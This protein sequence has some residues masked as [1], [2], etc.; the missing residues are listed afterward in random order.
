MLLPLE[1]NIRI[2]KDQ[3]NF[4]NLT[5]DEVFFI[6]NWI[7]SKKGLKEFY[8]T[9]ASVCYISVPIAQQFLPPPPPP[10]NPM[11][12]LSLMLLT[13]GLLEVGDLT[14]IAN[15]YF[16]GNIALVHMIVDRNCI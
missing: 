11:R 14:A 7:I 8:E 15:N 1:K 13:K 9:S 2:I 6:E 10:S 12:I 16:G 5:M 3:I 4:L